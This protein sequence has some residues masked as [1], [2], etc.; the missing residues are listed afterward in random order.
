MLTPVAEDGE[1]VA[2]EGA[3]AKGPAEE[4]PF[5]A[6]E[7]HHHIGKPM[8]DHAR[9]R[10]GPEHVLSPN[11]LIREKSPHLLQHATNPV[12]WYPWSDEAFS[13]A[14]REEKPVFLSIGYATCHWCHVMAHESF[15]DDGVA[16]ILNRDFVCIKID[17]EERPDIDAVYVAVSQMLTGRG[18]LPLTI[19]M[20]TEKRPFFAGTY[21]PKA[22]RFGRTGIIDLLEK[23]TSFWHERRGEIL[24]SADEIVA[25]LAS[26]EPCTPMDP[27]QSL[28]TAGY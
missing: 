4:D 1:D 10:S 15:E 9:K 26:P 8:G 18:G 6:R 28:L 17:R 19:V 5:H 12:D 16:A 7:K 25:G 23:I 11:R 2:D 3:G 21:I 14:A 20:T 22:G 24:R 27:D 13:R